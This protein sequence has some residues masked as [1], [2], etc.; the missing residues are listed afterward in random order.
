MGRHKIRDKETSIRY[1][2]ANFWQKINFILLI[3]IELGTERK[4]QVN[5]SVPLLKKFG[6]N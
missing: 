5:F 1:K 4:K 2:M 3:R 6:D